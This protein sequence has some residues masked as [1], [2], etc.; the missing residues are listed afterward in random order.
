MLS[1][2]FPCDKENWSFNTLTERL[3]CLMGLQQVHASRNTNGEVKHKKQK[4]LKA[5]LI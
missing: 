3:K 2:I 1:V 5:Y 4:I